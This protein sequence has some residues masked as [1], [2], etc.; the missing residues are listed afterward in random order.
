M[1][2]LAPI[3]LQPTHANAP[4]TMPD[5]SAI[6]F[7]WSLAK[8]HHV[9]ID[10]R[11][12]TVSVSVSSKLGFAPLPEKLLLISFFCPKTDSTT[13]NNFTCQCRPGFEG[14]LC[15]TPFCETEPCKNGGF[16]L[17][18]D[19]SPVCQCSL[20]YTGVF[21]ETDINECEPAPCENGGECID[22]IGRYKCRC[23]GTGFE[24]PN[25]E[26]DIDECVEQRINCGERGTCVNTRG[27]YR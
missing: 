22:L 16:C 10:R 17:K 21:C 19:A 26:T 6:Y 5:H 14:T 15:D 27:S 8:I 2:A 4:T 23:N 12:L 24:G 13:G 18:T 7:D 11:V 20:G 25:C 9:E 1:A 3:Y